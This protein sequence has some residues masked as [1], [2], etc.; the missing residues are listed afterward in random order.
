M[1]TFI[2]DLFQMVKDAIAIFNTEPLNYF[3]YLA[4]VGGA[5]VLARKILPRKKG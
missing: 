5:I 1:P 3:V 4:L 2:A